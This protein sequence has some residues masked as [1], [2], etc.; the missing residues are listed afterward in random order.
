MGNNDYFLATISKDLHF[1]VAMSLPNTA[2]SIIALDVFVP[3]GF[4]WATLV[5]T[6][7]Q[8]EKLFL[9]SV[10]SFGI[11]CSSDNPVPLDVIMAVVN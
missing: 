9:G 8:I 1:F 10:E 5:S 7:L 11:D 6:V 2:T 3:T 4:F